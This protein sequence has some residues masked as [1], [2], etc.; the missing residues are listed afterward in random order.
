MNAVDEAFNG[1]LGELF[2]HFEVEDAASKFIR[3]FNLILFVS[4]A[5][6]LCWVIW[7]TITN[8]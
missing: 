6:L 1:G 2:A 5:L 4:M 8:S 3:V 7:S